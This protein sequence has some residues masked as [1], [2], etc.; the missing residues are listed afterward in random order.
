M[1]QKLSI[2]L[3][4]FVTISSLLL[5]GDIG[6]TKKDISP[7]KPFVLVSP[8]EKRILPFEYKA[9][10]QIVSIEDIQLVA[11]VNG[12]LTKRNFNPG[13][14]VKKGQLLFQ[15]QKEQ[16]QAQVENAAANVLK[17]QVTY[18]N[19]LREYNRQTV[20]IKQNATSQEA[21]DN[22]IQA[23][24]AAKAILKSAKAQLM[25]QELN[26]SYTDVSA[27]FDGRIGMYTYSIGNFVGKNSKPLASV[28]MMDP[29]WVEFPIE[30]TLLVTEMQRFNDMLSSAKDVSADKVSKVFNVRLMLSNGTWYP[31]AGKINY[32]SNVIDPKA[33]TIQ[34]R[35]VFMNPDELL[36]PGAFATIS[37]ESITTSPRLTIHQAALQMSQLGPF[38]YVLDLKNSTV[39]KRY[40]QLG[41]QLDDIYVIV[42]DGL[43]EGDLVVVEGLMRL[44]PGVKVDYKF[45]STE[46]ISTDTHRDSDTTRETKT[47]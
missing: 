24:Y 8:V 25:L 32:L 37:L 38:V 16:Y 36:V 29:I 10:G 15:I 21:V 44:R 40:L 33:G 35:A 17:A 27:P 13:D 41:K 28:V 43:K 1:F 39:Q 3:A 20:M 47:P 9:V 5:F 23:M 42:K 22:S 18:D 7:P 12:Y 31:L 6:C 45:F 34:A 11:R 2:K 19:D 14:F 26:L 4:L 46:F 30:E